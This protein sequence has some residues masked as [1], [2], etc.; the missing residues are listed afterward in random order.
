MYENFSL[1]FLHHL[2]FNLRIEMINERF[3]HLENILSVRFDEIKELIYKIYDA[4]DDY[5]P[6]KLPLRFN[7]DKINFETPR[8]SEIGRFNDTIHESLEN[9]G[10]FVFLFFFLMNVKNT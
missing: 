8:Q 5:N 7:N 6:I 3:T 2:Y 4:S 9:D 1:Q 10:S